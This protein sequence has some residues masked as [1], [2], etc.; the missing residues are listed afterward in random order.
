M[1]LLIFA[2]NKKHQKAKLIIIGDGPERDKAVN[3]AIEH[4]CKR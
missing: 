3:I 2:K 1:S 4:R